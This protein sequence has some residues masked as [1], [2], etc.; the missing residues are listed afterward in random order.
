MRSDGKTGFIYFCPDYPD[1]S[2]RIAAGNFL[3][4][5]SFALTG[6]GGGKVICPAYQ[7]SFIHDQATLK[8][9]FSYFEAD[10]TPKVFRGASKNKF[11]VAVPE[12]YRKK[13]RRLQT[14]EMKTIYP[15]LPDSL[16]A[17]SLSIENTVASGLDSLGNE[18]SD[19]SGMVQKTQEFR[20][21]KTREKY[22]NDQDYYMWFFRKSLLLPDIRYN[23]EKRVVAKATDDKRVQAASRAKPERVKKEGGFQLPFRR[24]KENT[25]G[26]VPPAKSDGGASEGR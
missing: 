16:P 15:V 24:K 8:A 11:L 14:V 4:I 5:L 12:S 26:S 9:K 25:D 22:N 2:M 21:T 19:E 23:L 6:C 17:D 7:S 20:L 18:L 1:L 10:S 3:L 13:Y